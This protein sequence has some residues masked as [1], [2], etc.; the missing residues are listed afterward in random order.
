MLS[1]RRSSLLTSCAALVA[2]FAVGTSAR[3]LD[4]P[5]VANLTLMPKGAARK[6][7]YYQPERIMLTPNRPNKVT[8]EPKY[9]NPPLYGTIHFG[10][11][12]DDTIAVVLDEAPDASSGKL[13][14]DANGDGDLTNDP[15]ITW[16]RRSQRFPDGAG[17]TVEVVTFQGSSAITPRLDLLKNGSLNDSVA[18]NV[19]FYRFSPETAKAKSPPLP[20]DIL[21]YYRDYAAF[22]SVKLGAKTYNIALVDE[23]AEGRFDDIDHEDGG[24]PRVDLLIDRNGDGRFDPRYER[25]DL[26][27]PFSIDGTTY[28]AIQIASDGSS[29]TLQK[30][31][32]KVAEIPIPADLKSG[33]QALSFV[34]PT[35]EGGQVHFPQDFKHKLVMLDFWATWCP[36]CRAEIPGLVKV[37]EKYHGQGFEVLGVSL[38]RANQQAAVHGFLKDEE[39]TWK[40]VYDGKKAGADVA[41]LYGIDAIPSAFLIDGNTGAIVA[42][43]DDLRGANLEQTVAKALDQLKQA[44]AR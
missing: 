25:F 18:R 33:K 3:S 36:P 5:I 37:Y 12:K 7:G 4:A 30:N 34:R 40:Q 21:L 6:L 9:D 24:K 35:F 16:E 19:M 10:W 13:Y 27:Y 26:D 42:F 32:R 28:Q 29:L 44:S 20:T 39:M 43:G 11:A 41:Q 1:I 15:P 2:A 23:R 22:G 38:D 31:G 14:V 8:R 17:K